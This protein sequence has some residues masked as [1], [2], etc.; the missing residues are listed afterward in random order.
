MPTF[1]QLD[2]LTEF[3]EEYGPE[4]AQRAEEKLDP[5]HIPGRDPISFVWDKKFPK[6]EFLR[7]PYE[8]QAHVIEAAKKAL[9]HEAMVWI[10]G[11]MG[12]G[13][14]MMGMCT[15]HVHA[16]GKPYRGLVVCPDHLVHKWRREIEQT[17]PNAIVDV[18]TH[19]SQMLDIVPVTVPFMFNSY[20]VP[21]GPEW[22][23]IGRDKCK[24]GPSWT[25][26]VV[27]RVQQKGYILTC[28][29]CGGTILNDDGDPVA[30]KD[31]PKNRR[32]LKCKAMV[33]YPIC[34]D[35]GVQDWG[36]RE[37]GEILW[38]WNREKFYRWA[39]ERIINKKLRNYYDYLILDE[40]HEYKGKDTAQANAAGAIA[41]V[42]KNTIALTGTLIGGYATHIFPL[43]YRL[44][45]RTLIEEGF[46][47]DDDM[48]FCKKYGK[49]KRIEKESKKDNA[50]G[51]KNSRGST[52]TEK[53]TKPAPGIMPSLFRHVMGHTVFLGLSELAKNLPKLDEGTV[54]SV[55]DSELA[56]AVAEINEKLVPIAVEMAAQGNI[57]LLGVM[58]EVLLY[59]PDHPWG[60]PEL[61]YIDDE[62][63]TWIGIMTPKELSSDVIRVKEKDYLDYVKEQRR[64]GSQV[65]TYIQ[66]NGDRDVL[67]RLERLCIAKHLGVTSLR[68]SVKR[69]ERER[70]IEKQGK[71][72]DVM[73]SHP[74]LVETGLDL[75]SK[76]RKHGHNYNSLY[77]FQTGY[78]SFTTMQASRRSWRLGQWKKCNVRYGYYK[79]TAQEGCLN[80]MAHKLKA[81]LALQGQYSEDGL[82][83]MTGDT[84]QDAMSMVNVISK[85][86]GDT[87]RLWEQVTNMMGSDAHA[88]D[89]EEEEDEQV[90]H[91]V[92]V[93]DAMR[94]R[95]RAEFD[96]EVAIVLQPAANF[97]VAERM[98][99]L[100]A[101]MRR[102]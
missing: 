41:A 78:R 92:K 99:Q 96:Q 5:L 24:L 86:M 34:S 46:E 15:A 55:M 48:E 12:T 51:N 83:A 49:I 26:Q 31:L 93:D 60:W 100:R 28:P 76:D 20:P 1:D 64:K 53:T 33:E 21:D 81:M 23:I 98:K 9:L 95:F 90:D 30:M 80:L 7:K 38:S 70:W 3:F 57:K 45:P 59:Y 42:A 32:K 29:K 67:A 102:S 27:K 66:R 71:G 74:Q 54:E 18:V 40:V 84:G 47:H 77:F 43:T 63:E 4:L 58:L 75:F 19:W 73:I 39:P 52:K 35:E 94:A 25:P 65:W 8:P 82:S 68:S 79:G 72:V 10:I 56:E 44:C 6:G 101:K 97:D 91:G 87:G 61:G 36:Y 2:T 22:T 85:N 14:T 50:R 69:D 62:T 13:K 37:C 89:L 16:K 11:E 17:I 88:D